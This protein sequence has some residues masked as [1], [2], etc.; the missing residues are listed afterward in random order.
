MVAISNMVNEEAC[1]VRNVIGLDRESVCVCVSLS[2]SLL[3]YL[4]FAPLS[5][6]GLARK[7]TDFRIGGFGT[8][9]GGSGT[10]RLPTLDMSKWLVG[11]LR[12]TPRL[13]QRQIIMAKGPEHLHFLS[14]LLL[15]AFALLRGFCQ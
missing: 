15:S 8:V 4:V 10:A 3:L 2:L 11:G 6:W 1:M 13:A 9:G 5:R 14:A 7:G 12:R